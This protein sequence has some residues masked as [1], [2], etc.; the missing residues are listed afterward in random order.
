MFYYVVNQ[1]NLNSP[2][3]LA[4]VSFFLM[5]SYEI[6][7]TWFYMKRSYLRRWCS[8]AFRRSPSTSSPAISSV[9]R[10][11][12]GDLSTTP[13]LIS[14]SHFPSDSRDWSDT[15]GKSP[16]FRILDG[17]KR[18]CHMAPCLFGYRPM[19]KTSEKYS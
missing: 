4:S 13:G 7:V 11:I 14:L 3:F 5:T 12:T 19:D 2:S 18:C 8:T 16:L 10:N 9:L 17:N 15:S 1:N 6:L